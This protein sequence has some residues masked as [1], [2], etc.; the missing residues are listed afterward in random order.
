MRSLLSLLLTSAITFPC[1]AQDGTAGMAPVSPQHPVL[2]VRLEAG[3]SQG[4]LLSEEGSASTIPATT[5]VQ[6]RSGFSPVVSASLLYRPQALGRLFFSTG[7]GVWGQ[8]VSQT[9]QISD[10]NFSLFHRSVTSATVLA[11]PLRVGYAV[12]PDFDIQAGVSIGAVF[13]GS[14]SG[15]SGMTSW[16]GGGWGGG[17]G[18]MTNTVTSQPTSYTTA[19]ADV[20]ASHAFGRRWLISVRGVYNFKATPTGG[21]TMEF[22]NGTTATTYN[23]GGERVRLAQLMV[24]TGVRLF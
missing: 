22:F 9:L 16:G 21:S 2:E 19:I 3:I 18:T 11:I 13:P 14:S 12:T 20:Q 10:Q 8:R 17:W 4:I 1:A 6:T 15:S 24:T 7:M 23:M 5:G